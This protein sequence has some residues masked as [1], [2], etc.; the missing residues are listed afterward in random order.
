MTEKIS[1]SDDVLSR[2][3]FFYESIFENEVDMNSLDSRIKLQKL[4]YILKSEGVDFG[5]NFTWYI[6]GP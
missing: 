4:V 5:Y 6:R 1:K 2:L 3:S